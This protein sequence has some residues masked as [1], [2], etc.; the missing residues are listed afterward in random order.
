MTS[1]DAYDIIFANFPV[2]GHE[3]DYINFQASSHNAALI[4]TV[5]F[6]VNEKVVSTIELFFDTS[7]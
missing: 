6:N 3:E 7:D 2:L 5:E 1:C 4:G